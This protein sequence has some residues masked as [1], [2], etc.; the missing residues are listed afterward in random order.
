MIK[1][2][3]KELEQAILFF[4]LVIY[5]TL[6]SVVFDK[7]LRTIEWFVLI[8]LVQFFGFATL[9]TLYGKKKGWKWPQR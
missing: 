8:W 6:F 5:M 7:E 9:L 4:S 2:F 1:K 3:Y